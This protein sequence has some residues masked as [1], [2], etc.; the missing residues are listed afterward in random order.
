MSSDHKLLKKQWQIAEKKGQQPKIAY[1][2]FK[3]VNFLIYW[4]KKENV[5]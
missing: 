1:V 2:Y 5:F 3:S 4:K